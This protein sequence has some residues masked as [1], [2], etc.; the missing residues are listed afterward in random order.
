LDFFFSFLVDP[1]DSLLLLVLVLIDGGATT[2]TALFTSRGG[3][4]QNSGGI[5]QELISVKALKK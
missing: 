3:N 2:S 4:L 1:G 5:V